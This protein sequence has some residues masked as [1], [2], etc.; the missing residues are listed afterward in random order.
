[1]KG[2]VLC[3]T[4]RLGVMDVACSVVASTH[5]IQNGKDCDH[6]KWNGL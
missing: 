1:M 5:Y 4:Q 2:I 3:H 6:V